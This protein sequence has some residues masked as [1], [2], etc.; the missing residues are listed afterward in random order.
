WR[1]RRAV[2]GDDL[3]GVG[4][5][6]PTGVRDG[7]EQRQI[8]HRR[9]VGKAASLDIRHGLTGHGTLKLEEQPRFSRARLADNGHD[10][11]MAF[12][13]ATEQPVQLDELAITSNEQTQRRVG[14][15]LTL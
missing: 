4:L 10:L 3:W 7:I 12:S 2:V 9:S 15:E 14:A 13:R 5:A 1:G 11:P 6:D 8:R